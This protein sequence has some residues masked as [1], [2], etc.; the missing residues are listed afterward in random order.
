MTQIREEYYPYSLDITPDSIY[1]IIGL[2]GHDA[3][4]KI[5]VWSL[6]NGN[7]KKVHEVY[8]NPSGCNQVVVDYTTST[9]D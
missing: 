5:T 2:V 9:E 3:E 8:S 1:L 6:R 7:I 4:G